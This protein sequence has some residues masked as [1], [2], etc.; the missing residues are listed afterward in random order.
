MNLVMGVS[1]HVVA[2]SFGRTIAAGPPA[3]VQR[4]PA[5]IEAYLGA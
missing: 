3:R 1:D 2:L 4:D 5:V